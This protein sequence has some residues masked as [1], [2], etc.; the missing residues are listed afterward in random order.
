MSAI[1]NS[2]F[3]SWSS[4]EA[5]EAWAV[6]LCPWC[7]SKTRKLGALVIPETCW[8]MGGGR[9]V[10]RKWHMAL[11]TTFIG[12]GIVWSILKCHR[13][14]PS[15]HRSWEKLGKSAFSSS[16]FLFASDKVY[17]CISY[18]SILRLQNSR[19]T[20]KPCSVF[21]SLLLAIMLWLWFTFGGIK[22]TC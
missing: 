1:L 19:L 15:W 17:L 12:D 7:W 14:V 22:L 13:Y 18:L 11:H 4:S 21:S 8:W 2:V 3:K 5:G 10:R 20:L 16:R 9:K 6:C